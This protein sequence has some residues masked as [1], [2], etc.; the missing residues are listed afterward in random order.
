MMVFPAVLFVCPYP[1]FSNLPMTIWS[2]P[3]DIDESSVWHSLWSHRISAIWTLRRCMGAKIGAKLLITNYRPCIRRLH[4]AQ[5]KYIFFCGNNGWITLTQIDFDYH[6]ALSYMKIEN[7]FVEQKNHN[8]TFIGC[9]FYPDR[10]WLSLEKLNVA[11]EQEQSHV[12]ASCPAWVNT[13]F[14][15]CTCPLSPSNYPLHACTL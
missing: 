6:D 9:R 15:A 4:S 3:R 7:Q 10:F 13:L 1:W 11:F 8:L 5:Q 14:M 12:D 2:Y